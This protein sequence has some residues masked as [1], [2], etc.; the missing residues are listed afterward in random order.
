MA[1]VA[2]KLHWTV[3]PLQHGL[4]VYRMIELDCA[5]INAPR[6]QS[7]KLRMSGAEP[8]DVVRELSRSAR[9]AKVRVALRAIRVRSSRQTPVSPM[10]CVAGG[11]I[12]REQLIGMVRRAIMTRAAGPIARLGAERASVPNMALA[13]PCAKD[14][15]SG[16]HLAAAI[17]AIVASKRRPGQPNNR[18]QRQ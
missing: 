8:R 15:M 2:I 5:R 14:C 17:H 9:G 4:Q 16:G 11:A 6:S 1:I 7:S 18:Q 13:T 3:R 10:F 12:R